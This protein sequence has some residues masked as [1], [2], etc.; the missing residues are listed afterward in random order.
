MTKCNRCG[1]EILFRHVDGILK[2]IHLSGYCNGS[3]KNRQPML[4]QE[5]IFT[6]PYSYESFVNPHAKCPVCGQEVFYYQSFH[7]SRVF[8]DSLGPPWPKHACTDNPIVASKI[9]IR[10]VN[11]PA[12]ESYKKIYAWQKDG[13]EPFYVFEIEEVHN[14]KYVSIFGEFKGNKIKVFIRNDYEFPRHSPIHLKTKDFQTFQLSTITS[15]SVTRSGLE[16]NYTGYS[17]LNLAHIYSKQHKK[18]DNSNDSI[19]AKKKMNTKRKFKKII[20]SE[21]ENN[22]PIENKPKQKTAMQIAFEKAKNST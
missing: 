22:H 17:S 10:P 16:V 1:G 18:S 12:Q 9:T 11:S 2:P 21:M 7:G 4:Q 5:R 20:P 6:S 15:K 14:N 3:V 13:W 19:S 8:F